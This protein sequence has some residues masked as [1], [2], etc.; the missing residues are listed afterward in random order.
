M[1]KDTGELLKA[2][3]GFADF[4]DFYAENAGALKSVSLSRALSAL[5][6]EK[7]LEKAAVVVDS[8]LSEVYAYQILSG[9][10]ANPARNKVLCLTLA[11]GL[12]LDETQKLLKT[13][14]YAPLYAKNPF[15]CVVIYGILNNMRVMDV[16]ALL[17]DYTEETLT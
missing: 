4:G 15:D 6:E 8:Q 14:G 9:V 10:R 11:M 12:T 2:L 13:T 5:I 17:F 1:K 16:N 7:G 3:E